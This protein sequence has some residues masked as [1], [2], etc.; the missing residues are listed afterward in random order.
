M[1]LSSPVYATLLVLMEKLTSAGRTRTSLSSVGYHHEHSLL[2]SNGFTLG[3][4]LNLAS[5]SIERHS[6]VCKK[7]MMGLLVSWAT[8]LMEGVRVPP[9]ADGAALAVVIPG[10]EPPEQ[11]WPIQAGRHLDGQP[12]ARG[13]LSGGI[14][15]P[16]PPHQNPQAVMCTLL[17]S[18]LRLETWVSQRLMIVRNNF[19]PMAGAAGWHAK[20]KYLL[21]VMNITLCICLG[22]EQRRGELYSS[23]RII[24]AALAK[25]IQELVQQGCFL[26]CVNPPIERSKL[27]PENRI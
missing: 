15:L 18:A 11:G 6:G 1:P 20:G 14:V 24:A 10:G 9:E 21:L 2:S 16:A 22:Q 25:G 26:L 3:A 19:M 5:L 13:N 12:P 17:F 8:A 23:H 4:F 7:C 27:C